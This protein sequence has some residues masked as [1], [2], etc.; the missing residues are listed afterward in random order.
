MALYKF[1]IKLLRYSTEPERRIQMLSDQRL[2]QKQEN[3]HQD[4]LSGG[5][6][7]GSPDMEFGVLSDISTLP[8]SKSYVSSEGCYKHTTRKKI[9]PEIPKLG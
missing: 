9:P 8:R 3:Q 2:L 5:L 7:S 1:W 6:T 4:E